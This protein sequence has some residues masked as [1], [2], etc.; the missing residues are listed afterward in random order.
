MK[1]IDMYEH[2]GT[3]GAAQ[4][5]AYRKYKYARAGIVQLTQ[6]VIRHGERHNRPATPAVCWFLES[7]EAAMHAGIYTASSTM[8]D[9]G[10]IV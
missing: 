2:E 1:A 7:C 10:I 4:Q 6:I 9:I 3:R 5:C 8:C